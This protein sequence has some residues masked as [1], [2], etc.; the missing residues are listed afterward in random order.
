[1]TTRT[2]L[3]RHYDEAGVCLYIGITDDLSTRDKDHAK[4][5]DWH[6]LV[7]RS[8]TQWFNSRVEARAA[9][10]R[11]IL[12]ERPAHNRMSAIKDPLSYGAIGM[13]LVELRA[14]EG[15][16]QSEFASLIGVKRSRYSL[17]ECGAQRLSLD[18]AL[19]L[20]KVMG[21]SLDWLFLG[22]DQ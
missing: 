3:Y 22:D 15:L 18:G 8:E 1:M 10:T 21:V 4:G 12:Q 6:K 19:T 13:R 20:H 16:T 9:E 17:W 5:A 11:A 14:A 7:A 2:A